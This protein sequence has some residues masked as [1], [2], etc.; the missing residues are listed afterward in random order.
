MAVEVNPAKTSAL[1][2]R[3][4]HVAI[5]H[6]EPWFE[7]FEIMAGGEN[8]FLKFSLRIHMT[9]KALVYHQYLNMS[10]KYRQQLKGRTLKPVENWSRK[11][12][13]G[14]TSLPDATWVFS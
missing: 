7:E 10:D 1:G 5:L 3:P 4:P 13:A 12:G 11:R 9:N 2:S 8:W 14:E 6:H